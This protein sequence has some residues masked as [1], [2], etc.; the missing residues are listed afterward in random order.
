MSSPD[1]FATI[2]EAWQCYF[3]VMLRVGMSADVA[4]ESRRAFYGGAAAVLDLLTTAARVGNVE[5]VFR[6]RAEAQEFAKLQ[7]Q[8]IV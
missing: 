5:H 7:R 3:A 6:L 4:V 2:G 8:G 1:S